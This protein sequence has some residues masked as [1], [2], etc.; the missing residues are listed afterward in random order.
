MF[1]F[2]KFNYLIKVSNKVVEVE[3]DSCP[4]RHPQGH[5]SK[6]PHCNSIREQINQ[7]IHSS[8]AHGVDM[9]CIC[10]CVCACVCV[11]VCVL[12]LIHI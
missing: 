8:N 2:N 4:F 5:R 6:R 9:V 12:S 10:V 7:L 3:L 11:C 1:I